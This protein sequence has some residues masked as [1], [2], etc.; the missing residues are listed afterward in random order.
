MSRP[1]TPEEARDFVRETRRLTP[2]GARTK[3]GLCAVDDAT[4]LDL[5]ALSGIIDY[6][7]EEFTVSVLAGTPVAELEARLA[8]HR[9]VLPFDPPWADAGAT[10]GGTVAAGLSGSGRYRYGGVRD[11]II[12]VRFVDGRGRLAR[13]GGRVVKNAAGFDL[14][15]LLVGSRGCLAVLVELTFKVFPRPAAYHTL[16]TRLANTV[17]ALDVLCRLNRMDVGLEAL[18]FTP[19]STLWLRLGGEP[20]ALDVQARRLE[21]DLPRPLETLSPEDDDELWRD[22][23]A[24]HWRP[25]TTKE[26]TTLVKIPTTPRHIPSI[27]DQLA[28]LSSARRYT[29]GGNLLWLAWP[30]ERPLAELDPILSRLGLSGLALD[31]PG[32]P[33]HLGL[34]PARPFLARIKDA[35]DPDGRLPSF[36]P[37]TTS[38]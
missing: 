3:P 33:P 26:P 6:Q 28:R 17:Q 12:G 5:T 11:F 38:D 23:R 31:R 27:E 22:V 1:T 13:G 2:H 25:D 8:E 16:R 18:D 37:E 10:V 9:Q 21:R 14:P 7:P 30:A 15:K 24:F 36:H 20:Q 35:L 32:E 34:D 19:P 29:V 4:P